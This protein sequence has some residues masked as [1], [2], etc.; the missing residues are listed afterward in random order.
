MKIVVWLFIAFVLLVIV[1]GVSIFNKLV[2]ARNQAKN[3]FA[4]IDVQLKRRHDLIPN[5]VEAAKAYLVHESGTLEAV[6]R[7]RSSAEKSLE[8]A[9]ASPNTA[10]LASL[11]QQES[12]SADEPK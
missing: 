6:V 4:Q 5:L 1:F 7:A 11:M 9:A 3:G 12:G 2:R 10:A 8:A